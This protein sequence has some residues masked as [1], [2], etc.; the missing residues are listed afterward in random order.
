MCLLINYTPIACFV[1]GRVKT[2]GWSP[3]RFAFHCTNPLPFTQMVLDYEK[4]SITYHPYPQ[5][6]PGKWVELFSNERSYHIGVG[7]GLLFGL[8]WTEHQQDHLDPSLFPLTPLSRVPPPDCLF[9]LIKGLVRTA[10]LEFHYHQNLARGIKPSLVM[11]NQGVGL[12]LALQG[13][14][15]F[16]S[17]TKS[18]QIMDYVLTHEHR[19]PASYPT[20][21]QDASQKIRTAMIN[22][23]NFSVSS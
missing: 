20:N 5:V 22:M 23:W 15:G 19:I 2:S 14:L 7:Q 3:G 18:S 10:A 9:G 4:T 13:N 6:T 21:V 17:P 8:L 12:I 1:S 11:T 16:I